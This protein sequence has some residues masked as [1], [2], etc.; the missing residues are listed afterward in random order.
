MRLFY[1]SFG[2]AIYSQGA[3]P[4]QLKLNLEN[5]LMQFC[6]LR[7]ELLDKTPV[8]VVSKREQAQRFG[9]RLLRALTVSVLPASILAVRLL[10]PAVQRLDQKNIVLLG[11]LIWLGFNLLFILDP[12]YSLTRQILGLA[13]KIRSLA[14]GGDD[15]SPG[16]EAH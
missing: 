1:A 12:G 2:N 14:G 13:G 15:S 4:E 5:T 9:E 7:W 6:N 11:A 16:A 3:I 8:P 10:V